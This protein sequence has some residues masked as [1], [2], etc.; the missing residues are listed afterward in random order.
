MFYVGIKQE[1]LTLLRQAIAIQSHSAEHSSVAVYYGPNSQN[2]SNMV[3]MEPSGF[4]A[5]T[6]S[7]WLKEVLDK[8]PRLGDGGSGAVTV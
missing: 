2:L 1:G 7:K 6:E 3:V 4:A 8:A 5:A